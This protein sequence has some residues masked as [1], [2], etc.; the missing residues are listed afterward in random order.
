[1]QQGH[2]GFNDFRRGALESGTDILLFAEQQVSLESDLSV[3]AT[4]PGTY[5]AGNPPPGGTIPSGTQVESWLLH[6]DVPSGTAD[7]TTT[8]TFD[9]DILGVICRPQELTASDHLAQGSNTF[10]NN[11]WR[12]SILGRSAT[13]SSTDDRF[14]ILEVVRSNH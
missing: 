13:E 9:V 7:F 5:D 3:N 2:P 10:S 8:I 6:Q 12:G 14:T 4:E 11:Q 1:M